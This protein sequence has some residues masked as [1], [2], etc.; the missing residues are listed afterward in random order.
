MAIADGKQASSRSKRKDSPLADL[1]P[2]SKQQT[3]SQLFSSA[4]KQRSGNHLS[5][6][7]S[8]G[9]RRRL[10]P[11]ANDKTSELEHS[12]PTRPASIENMYSFNSAAA[13]V[14][15]STSPSSPRA[16]RPS[17]N[18][19]PNVFAPQNGTR[20]L[21][22][23][24]L[25]TTTKTD[26]D[27]FC[28]KTNVEL[29]EAL[30]AIFAGQR[31]ELSNEELYRGAENIC[32]LGRAEGLAKNLSER[33]YTQVLEGIK[34]PLLAEADKSN[35]E[36]LRAVLSA[37]ATWKKQTVWSSVPIW[38]LITDS[39]SAAAYSRYLLLSRPCLPHA[40]I[41]TCDLRLGNNL[42]QNA[43]LQR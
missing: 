23:K 33:C 32:K 5:E 20:K 2:T 28:S 42:V 9:K 18:L 17:S 31:P 36:V 11:I 4:E 26:P 39:L 3:L 14:D 6:S 34:K 40:N 10:S 30:T 25:R 19:R 37:W 15:P 1:N 21:L 38:Y 8:G 24:N 16:R 43:Y 35:V 29:D 7:P 13:A 27:R 41:T 12:L 22:V